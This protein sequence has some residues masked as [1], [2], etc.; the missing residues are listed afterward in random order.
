VI[1]ADGAIAERLNL[2]LGAGPFRRQRDVLPQCSLALSA[3]GKTAT[4]GDKQYQGRKEIPRRR[5]EIPGRYGIAALQLKSGCFI[6]ATTTNSAQKNAT[7]VA[8]S[9]E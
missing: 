4:P 7:P 3:R 5:K 9:N 1:Q 2:R 6:Y 8:A